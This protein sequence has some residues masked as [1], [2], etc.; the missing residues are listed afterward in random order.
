MCL[1]KFALYCYSIELDGVSAGGTISNK[2]T[3]MFYFVF[4]RTYFYFT[5]VVITGNGGGV[6]GNLTS[7][8]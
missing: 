2:L 5:G 8:P 4:T 7:F 3:L 6:V 1:H